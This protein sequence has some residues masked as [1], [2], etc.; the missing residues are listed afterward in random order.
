MG[1]R[2]IH[3][4]PMTNVVDFVG[5]TFVPVANSMLR[6]QTDCALQIHFGIWKSESAIF[7]DGLFVKMCLICSV[8]TE[9]SLT[10]LC[11]V[12]RYDMSRTTRHEV[13]SD[14]RRAIK[15]GCTSHSSH[16]SES[17]L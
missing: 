13:V 7:G 10:S 1:E 6:K 5:G 15:V 9:M 12:T 14:E 4:S 16:P 3:E 11:V 8:L 17:P 2:V